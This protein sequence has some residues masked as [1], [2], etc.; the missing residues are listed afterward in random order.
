MTKS[1]HILRLINK[2][3]L[4]LLMVLC[5]LWLLGL[6]NFG[7]GLGD[8]IYLPPIIFLPI[9]HFFLTKKFN[10]KGINHYLL[11]MIILFGI[12]CLIIIYKATI[13]RGGEFPWNGNIFYY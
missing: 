8:I 2:I 9:L 13:G 1:A 6:L 5:V 3:V 11:P 7:H 12:T 4:W 10:K